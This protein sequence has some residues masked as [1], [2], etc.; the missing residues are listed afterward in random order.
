MAPLVIT[1][2]GRGR[3][4][5]LLLRPLAWVVTLF[6]NS[7]QPSALGKRTMIPLR[8]I[9]DHRTGLAWLLTMSL[10]SIK[11]HFFGMTETL[12]KARAWL[13]CNLPAWS[14][15]NMIAGDY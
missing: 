4:K 8:S 15:K 10:L 3:G 11:K 2:P 14:L 12:K 1:A 9:P 13:P 7:A 5:R 6:G